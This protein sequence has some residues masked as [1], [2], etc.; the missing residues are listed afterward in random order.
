MDGE[1]SEGEWDDA[2][3]AE[4]QLIDVTYWRIEE[5]N[6]DTTFY[7]KNDAENVYLALVL[8]DVEY[9]SQMSLDFFF[10]VDRDGEAY[11]GDAGLSVVIW[12]GGDF[13]N[14]REFYYD[15]EEDSKM[16]SS[17]DGDK[18]GSGKLVHSNPGNGTVG[19]LVG[20][21]THPLDTGEVG[22]LNSRPGGYV[23]FGIEY[24][25]WEEDWDTANAFSW[26]E[27]VETFYEWEKMKALK[28]AFEPIPPELSLSE[29]LI[30][31]KTVTVN[32]ITLPGTNGTFVERISW[33]WGDGT[34]EDQWFEAQHTYAEY[35]PYTATITSHQS[36]S[37]TTEVSLV[38]EVGAR[39]LWD[40]VVLEIPPVT[41][42]G[43][44]Q[45]LEWSGRYAYDSAPFV[46]TLLLNETLQKSGVG[47]YGYRV[48]GIDDS[49]YGIASFTA[50]DFRVVYDRVN[51]ELSLADDRIN[52]GDEPIVT[53]I[54]RYEYDDDQFQGHVE[55]EKPSS[56][57]TVG[58]H[59]YKIASIEDSKYGIETFTSNEVACIWD[60]LVIVN[61]GSSADSATVG[62]AVTVWYEVEYEYDGAPFNGS[63]GTLSING[64]E[65]GWSTENLR[66]ELTHSTESVGEVGFEITEVVDEKHGLES[67][68]DEV[69]LILVEWKSRGI[70]GFPALSVLIGA[71]AAAIWVY[72]RQRGQ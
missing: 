56:H 65:A 34:I 72:A 62:E 15:P 31:E 68:E 67:I 54:G 46:G 10:D 47:E 32:G 22:D 48:M 28:F 26:P 58:S 6:I 57:E 59:V 2:H 50:N 70:P 13:F 38:L 16:Y 42:L 44:G 17:D 40:Q 55:L 14:D 39:A 53:I 25:W 66:W 8:L 19:T 27:G 36:D 5:P 9:H 52:V 3:R 29:P 33:D 7:V 37:L 61:G 1:I 60:R 30:E 51:L 43:I 18:D 21:Y 71:L 11:P 4:I 49:V 45:G 23:N 63:C 12:S 69:G 35:G 41:R 64:E 20:E 24:H